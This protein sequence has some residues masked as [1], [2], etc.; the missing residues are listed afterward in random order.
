M[1]IERRCDFE[2]PRP[3]FRLGRACVDFFTQVLL[4]FCLELPRK[5]STKGGGICDARFEVDPVNWLTPEAQD[6]ETQQHFAHSGDRDSCTVLH[7]ESP[8]KGFFSHGI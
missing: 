4:W 3:S 6:P 8:T 7:S 1:H 2:L 5:A